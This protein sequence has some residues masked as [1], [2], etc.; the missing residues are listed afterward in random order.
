MGRKQKGRN[1]GREEEN[2]RKEGKENLWSVTG[3]Y[4]C[5]YLCANRD[6]FSFWIRILFSLCLDT[7]STGNPRHLNRKRPNTRQTSKYIV[8]RYMYIHTESRQNSTPYCQHW[9]IPY[10]SG[11]SNDVHLTI[12]IDPL[13]LVESYYEITPGGTSG[14]SS[15]NSME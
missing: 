13:L 8:K 9:M 14:I 2:G 10:L 3:W 5:M 12:A 1:L 11:L 4:V 6:F 7:L 15:M